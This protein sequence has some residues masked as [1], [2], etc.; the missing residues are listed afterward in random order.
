MKKHL[1][2]IAAL[3]ASMILSAQYTQT[4]PLDY[5]DFFRADAVADGGTD[6][7]K[8][9]YANTSQGDGTPLMADQW[10]RIGKRSVC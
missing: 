3:A 2:T 10:N 1:F 7:E 8:D 6:L 4:L 9:A 5:E